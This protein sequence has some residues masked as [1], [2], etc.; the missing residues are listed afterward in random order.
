MIK[1]VY[2]MLHIVKLHDRVFGEIGSVDIKPL[3]A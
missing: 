2:G 1:A 3:I